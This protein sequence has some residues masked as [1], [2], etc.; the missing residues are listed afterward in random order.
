MVATAL[1]LDGRCNRPPNNGLE[2]TAT[3][4]RLRLGRASAAQPIAVGH[5]TGTFEFQ[6]FFFGN[7]LSRRADCYGKE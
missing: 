5:T 3:L 6:P 1:G 4:P 2:P 7:T